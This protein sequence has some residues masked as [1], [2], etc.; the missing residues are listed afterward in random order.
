ME[1]GTGTAWLLVKTQAHRGGETVVYSLLTNDLV[2]I[3]LKLEIK[4]KAVSELDPTAVHQIC[5]W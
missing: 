4:P 1:E 3:Q 5:T 2:S